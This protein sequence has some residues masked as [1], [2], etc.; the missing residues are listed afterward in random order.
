MFAFVRFP[1]FFFIRTPEKGIRSGYSALVISYH[2]K[3]G[4]ERILL[5]FLNQIFDQK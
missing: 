5:M 1:R 3:E 2:L 4:K